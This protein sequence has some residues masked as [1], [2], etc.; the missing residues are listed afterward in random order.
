[1]QTD[2]RT[3]W[4]ALHDRIAGVERAFD[5]FVR[6]SSLQNEDP[7]GIKRKVFRPEFRALV[8][9]VRSFH[10][11]H[12]A[13]IPRSAVQTINRFLTS[14]AAFV[15]DNDLDNAP[16]L[17]ACVTTLSAFRTELGFQLAG[18]AAAWVRMT[19]RAIQH[20]QR[21]IVAD[22]DTRERWQ[23][24][25]EE[26]ELACERLGA[27]HL[28]LHGVWAFKV[29]ATGE[30]TDLV[31]NERIADPGPIVRT[32]DT[33]VLTEW[34]LVR[35]LAEIERKAEAAIRQ[36]ELYATGVLGGVELADSRFV[37]LVSQDRLSLPADIER[38]GI[39]YLT[40][41]I[42]VAP[43]SPSKTLSS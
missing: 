3:D 21:S 31:Y 30:R 7:Y 23:L 2:W 43:Q 35:S 28:L 34:K 11:S 25:F 29:S 41:G 10:E 42:A 26:G 22:P 6:G 13:A 17:V 37:I 8:S 40:R 19:E 14:S 39:S 4:Q 24:A 16:H 36:A 12:A 15:G 18:R 5:L 1:M 20:L 9:I 33:L 38:G 32:A 27:V